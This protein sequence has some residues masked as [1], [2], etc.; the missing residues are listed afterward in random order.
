MLVCIERKELVESDKTR[1]K[2]AILATLSDM[3]GLRFNP[4]DAL[5][6]FQAPHQGCFFNDDKDR[7]AR[8]MVIFDPYPGIEEIEW[9]DK[10]IMAKLVAI[11]IKKMDDDW[12]VEVKVRCY[13]SSL[14]GFH[15]C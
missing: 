4:G 13:N 1:I 3:P 8:I 14:D 9:F 11:A 10:E 6:Q 7:T 15:C 2:E 5:F 12:K